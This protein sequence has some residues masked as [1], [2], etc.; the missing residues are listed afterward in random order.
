MEFCGRRLKS[1]ELYRRFLAEDV[2]TCKLYR[3]DGEVEHRAGLTATNVDAF[4]GRG[5]DAYSRMCETC[6]AKNGLIW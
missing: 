4:C 1:G 2:D 6:A 5:E 3:I